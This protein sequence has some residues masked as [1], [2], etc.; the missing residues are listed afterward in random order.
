MTSWRTTH[1]SDSPTGRSSGAQLQEQHAGDARLSSVDSVDTPRQDG[2]TVL[3][4]HSF[5]GMIVTDAGVHPNVSAIVYVAARAPDAGEDYTTLAKAIPAVKYLMSKDGGEAKR[6]VLEGTDYVYP[7]TSNTIIR[8]FLT[9][10][11]VKDDDIMENYTP[12][13]FS[14]WQIQWRPVTGTARW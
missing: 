6:F 4:G 13:G 2:P 1:P 9:S 3:A 5:S 12:F 8:A 14:D 7:R 11:G 10:V